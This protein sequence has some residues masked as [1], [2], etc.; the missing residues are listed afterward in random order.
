MMPGACGAFQNA[1]CKV[2]NANACPA[3]PELV[4]GS[5]VEGIELGFKPE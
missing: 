5:E 4:E 3:C 2:K 1:N